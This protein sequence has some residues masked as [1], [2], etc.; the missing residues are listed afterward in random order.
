LASEWERYVEDMRQ[1]RGRLN[2]V[3]ERIPTLEVIRE[4]AR[5]QLD[6]LELVSMLRFLRQNTG[7]VQSAVETLQGFGL[8]PLT[9]SRVRR[10]LG[11]QD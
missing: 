11:L 5:V 4:N 7:A 9:P 1:F 8:A 3:R 10:L 2:A 6:V